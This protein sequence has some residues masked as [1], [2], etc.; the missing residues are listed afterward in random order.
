MVEKLESVKEELLAANASDVAQAKAAGLQGPMLKRLTITEKVFNYMKS[1]LEKVAALEDPV[2]RVLE[3]HTQPTGLVVQKL[4]VPIG[5]VALIYESRPNVT[6]DAA[7]VCLKSGNA[8][9]LRGGSESLAS[10][11]VLV[12]A[13]MEAL[14]ESGL[15][16]DAVQL[17]EHKGHESVSTLLKLEEFVDVI[18]PRG[19]KGL[20][21]RISQGTN[22]PVIKHYEGICHLYLA[23]DAPQDWARDVAVNSKCQS[24]EVCNALETLL[25]DVSHIQENGS[26]KRTAD[27]S[28]APASSSKSLILEVCQALSGK[29]VEL[30]AC[31]QLQEYIRCHDSKNE[32]RMVAATEDDWTSEYLAPILSIKVVHGVEQAI[33]HINQYGSGHTDGIITQSLDLANRF[34]N[35]VDSASVLVNAST[36]LSGGGD[37]GMGAVVGIS[38]DKLHA[39]GPVGPSELTTY[40]WVA[41]GKGHLRR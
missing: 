30:R 10:N 6:T 32:I 37:Y 22:I 28:P 1:R 21:Q 11:Q 34:V 41:Y 38:T 19:G 26:R 12:K 2:G 24:I 8:V 20:I 15:P 29:G 7:C 36:R 23:S 3:G 31:P 39:R 18:I 25:V 5:V 35:G 33:R 40:K 4:S 16:A 17:I 27:G 9:I 13:M 14:Q